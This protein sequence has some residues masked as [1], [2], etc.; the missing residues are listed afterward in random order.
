[1]KCEDLV[2]RHELS[3]EGDGDFTKFFVS[4]SKKDW[5]KVEGFKKEVF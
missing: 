3:F 1:M 2:I 5:A 4:V